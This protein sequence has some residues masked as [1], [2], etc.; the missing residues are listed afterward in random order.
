MN[1]VGTI[2]QLLYAHQNPEYDKVKASGWQAAQVSLLSLMSF[3]GRFSIGKSIQK[4]YFGFFIRLNLL[5]THI[6]LI[7]DFVKNTCKLPRSYL[8]VLIATLFFVSQL[9]SARIADVSQLWIASSLVGLAHGSL[10]SLYPTVCLEW[11]GM[12]AYLLLCPLLLYLISSYLFPK[13]AHFSENWGYL[14]MSLL[15]GGNLFSLAFGRNLD[16]HSEH[17]Q[18]PPSP[19]NPELDSE[20]VQC[21]QGLDCYVHGIYLTIGATFLSIFLCVWAGCREKQKKESSISDISRGKLV[22]R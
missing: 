4:A 7:S 13:S 12:R 8:L 14:G 17:S 11:F 5:H 1:N 16:T 10:Y 19:N 20:P 22:G 6:G 21:L 15:A 18:I 3:L 2:S 9:V